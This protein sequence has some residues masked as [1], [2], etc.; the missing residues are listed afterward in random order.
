MEAQEQEGETRGEDR[1]RTGPEV[2]VD[3]EDQPP[4]GA[5]GDSQAAEE[6]KPVKLGVAVGQPL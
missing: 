5:G 3:G 1:I 2:F 4:E 6:E